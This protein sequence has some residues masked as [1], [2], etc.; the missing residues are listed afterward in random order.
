MTE[1]N[2]NQ[3]G[4]ASAPSPA[5]RRVDMQTTPRV[6]MNLPTRSAVE[7]HFDLVIDLPGPVDLGTTAQRYRVDWIE[8]GSGQPPG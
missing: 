5:A 1:I 7:T 2:P 8:P 4:Q 3:P 6:H